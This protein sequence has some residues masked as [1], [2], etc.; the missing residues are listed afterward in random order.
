MV[1]MQPN[2]VFDTE[3]PEG[4][5][6]QAAHMIQFYGTGVEIE[7]GYNAMQ[8]PVLRNRYFEY[9]SGGVKYGYMKDCMHMYYQE[10]Q[11]YYDTAKSPDP[12]VRMIYDYTYQFIKGTLNAYPDAVEVS[13]ATSQNTPVSLKALDKSAD[14]LTLDL[15]A[16]PAHGSVTLSNDGTFTYYPEAGFTGTVTF[17]FTYNEGLGDSQICTATITVE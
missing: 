3:V 9:L 7:I 2:Y 10:I 13:A 6:G 12:K 1:C 14:N 5:L 4:R 8:N 16:S 15:V 17:T 11:V